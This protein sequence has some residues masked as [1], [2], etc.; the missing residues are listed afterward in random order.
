MKKCLIKKNYLSKCN[1]HYIIIIIARNSIYCSSI[2][3][4]SNTKLLCLYVISRICLL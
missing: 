2:K 3:Y 1:Y 4:L